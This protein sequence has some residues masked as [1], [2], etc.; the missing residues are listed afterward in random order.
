M[1]YMSKTPLQM[2]PWLFED[3]DKTDVGSCMVVRSSILQLAKK[4]LIFSCCISEKQRRVSRP[5]SSGYACT[6]QYQVQHCIYVHSERKPYITATTH[7]KTVDQIYSRLFIWFF[8]RLWKL[9]FR[10]IIER[11]NSKS[12][13]IINNRILW[14]LMPYYIQDLPEKSWH[15]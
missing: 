5:I 8:N 9:S 13:N 10:K 3:W 15:I 6:G 1:K 14:N 12:L 2:G 11:L 7:S 4:N